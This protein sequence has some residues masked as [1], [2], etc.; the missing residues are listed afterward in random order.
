MGDSE[1]TSIPDTIIIWFLFPFLLRFPNRPAKLFLS[2]PDH[3]YSSSPRRGRW[4]TRPPSP[5]KQHILST[6][7]CKR[8]T[9]S[10]SWP[11]RLRWS[12][13]RTARQQ[14]GLLLPFP[15][16]MTPNGVWGN[17]FLPTPLELSQRPRALAMY[18]PDL[19]IPRY[20][21]ASPAGES[22]KRVAKF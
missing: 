17:V 16:W 3:K 14:A 5:F 6:P 10:S 12:L 9:G 2:S 20:E 21:I 19:T 1:S 11:S 4:I 15:G 18:T 22:Q 7:P 8:E 13:S